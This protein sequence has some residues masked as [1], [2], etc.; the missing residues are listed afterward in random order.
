[1]SVEALARIAGLSRYRFLHAYKQ[2]MGVTPI[3]DVRAK[4]VHKARQLILGNAMTMA[5]IA[6]QTGLGDVYSMSHTF[7]R[8][9]GVPP[10]TFRHAK[11]RAI[12]QRSRTSGPSRQGVQPP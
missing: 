4:R 2:A 6:D 1:L 9:L 11:R 10:G 5:D 12:K 3:A 7:R 8:T